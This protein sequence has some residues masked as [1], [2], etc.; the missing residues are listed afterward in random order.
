MVWIHGG[1]NTSGMTSEYNPQKLVAAQ[2]V[3]VVTIS[4]RLG[5]FG[6]FS[7]PELRNRSNGLDASANF[8]L[9][10]QIKALEWL[11]NNIENFGGDKNNIQYLVKV[12]VDKM[13]LPLFSP[14]AKGFPRA[15][16]QSGGLLLL[17]SRMQKI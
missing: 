7:H 9:L 8:G 14:I 5:I 10:D 11:R 4:Y 6:W 1:G 13:L 3:I 2:N 16:S 12:L 15:I 17:Q